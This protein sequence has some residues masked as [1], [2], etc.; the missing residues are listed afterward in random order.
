MIA[1]AVPSTSRIV[2]P[3]AVRAI[4]KGR[5]ATRRDDARDT[6]MHR[7]SFCLIHARTH[8]LAASRLNSATSAAPLHF[9][10]PASEMTDSAAGV[11][12]KHEQIN[13][14]NTAMDTSDSTSASAAADSGTSKRARLC[15]VPLSAG[16]LE[17]F[18]VQSAAQRTNPA[19]KGARILIDTNIEVLSDGTALVHLDV[20]FDGQSRRAQKKASRA[21][22]TS[23]KHRDKKAHQKA[24]KKAARAEAAQV[25]AVEEARLVA[26]GKSVD[27]IRAHFRALNALQGHRHKPSTRSAKA[28]RA[29][30]LAQ[31]A[32]NSLQKVIIDCSFDHLMLLQVSKQRSFQRANLDERQRAL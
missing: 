29:E 4:A 30:L 23:A 21:E 19:W 12:R 3:V 26:E 24:T 27:E 16:D 8:T 22:L 15:A 2:R 11:K 9:A 25:K 13:D 18:A 17:A 10:R 20:A 14:S 5:E 1:V 31:M 28:H 32:S 6:S 7:R